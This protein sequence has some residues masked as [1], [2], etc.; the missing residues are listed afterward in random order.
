MKKM[1]THALIVHHRAAVSEIFFS[2]LSL[3]ARIYP[4]LSIE[5]LS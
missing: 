3:T 5:S 1:I 4:L 2:D